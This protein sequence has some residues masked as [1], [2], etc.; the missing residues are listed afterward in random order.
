MSASLRPIIR[1]RIGCIKNTLATCV[2]TA[3]TS[4]F[5]SSRMLPD[6]PMVL[7]SLQLLSPVRMASSCSAV[8]SCAEWG[9]DV[10]GVT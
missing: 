8:F 4:V 9:G 7:G 6:C 1:K 3:A 2:P 5:V 10:R